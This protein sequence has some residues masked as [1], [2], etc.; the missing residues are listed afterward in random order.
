MRALGFVVAAHGSVIS[1]I[2]IQQ[3]RVPMP[4]RSANAT[5]VVHVGSN[6]NNGTNAGSFYLNSNN[7]ASNRNRNIGTRLIRLN[8][9][10]WAS[11]PLGEIVDHN[12]LVGRPNNWVWRNRT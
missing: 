2:Q 12:S 7:D 4:P 5:Q 6:A 9:L 8:F 11:S 10:G 3:N 1:V